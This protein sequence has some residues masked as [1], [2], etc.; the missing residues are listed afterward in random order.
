M[1][2]FDLRFFWLAALAVA[3]QPGC[4]L[5]NQGTR[6][7]STLFLAV[8]GALFLY[9]GLRFFFLRLEAGK[10]AAPPLMRFLAGVL[11]GV[12]ILLA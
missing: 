4:L 3:L 8:I 7:S 12:V 6:D 9:A 2:R 1:M 10:V 5:I 11:A